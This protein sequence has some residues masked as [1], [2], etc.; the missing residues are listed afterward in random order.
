[1]SAGKDRATRSGHVVARRRAHLRP[2][3]GAIKVEPYVAAADGHAAASH[4]GRGG[5]TWYTGSAGWMCRLIVESL[6][7]L[8]LGVDKMDFAPCLPADRK[9]F[10][11]H[12]RYRE[13]VYQ[14]AVLRTCD[15]D[16]DTG[17]TAGRR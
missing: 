12:Y 7:G 3:P 6:P 13:T 4:T 8:R 16:G 9:S 14:I 1:M 15:G 10:T 5:R 17:V 11:M 2:G